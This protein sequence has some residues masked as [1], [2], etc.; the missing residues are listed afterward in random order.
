MKD[1]PPHYIYT[2]DKEIPAKKI[3]SGKIIWT[4]RVSCMLDTL[5][6]YPTIGDAYDETNRRYKIIQSN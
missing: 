1:H 5:L 2:L 4:T 3:P 6:T